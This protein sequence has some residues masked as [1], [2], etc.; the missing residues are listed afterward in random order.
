M[1]SKG[2]LTTRLVRRIRILIACVGLV[3]GLAVLLV[4]TPFIQKSFRN[5]N[6]PSSYL[7]S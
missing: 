1:S 5:T 3:Y 7:Q 6:L 2:Q 4:M